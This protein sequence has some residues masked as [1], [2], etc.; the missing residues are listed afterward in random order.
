MIQKN[1]HV[2]W[3]SSGNSCYLTEKKKRIEINKESLR[4]L[5]HLLAH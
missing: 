3:E 5:G 4:N 1:R 2:N